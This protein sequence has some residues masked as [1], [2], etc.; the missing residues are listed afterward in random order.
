MDRDTRQ[1]SW[2]KA[3]RGEFDSFPRGARD[4]ITDALT[5]AA[6]GRKADTA[7]PM[8][9]FG[10]GVF[11]VAFAYRGEAYRAVYAL[12]LDRD[13]W[14]LHAFRKKSKTGIKTPKA[15]VDLIHERLR[16]LK[17]ALR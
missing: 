4:K 1:I 12:R 17:E 6:E 15:E 2:V 8:K 3:A 5:I 13:V 14:V 11:E 10:P 9:G 7:K 16:R